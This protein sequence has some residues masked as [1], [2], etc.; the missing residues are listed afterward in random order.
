LL[1]KGTDVSFRPSGRRMDAF[2]FSQRYGTADVTWRRSSENITAWGSARLAELTPRLM[3]FPG[4]VSSLT[5]TGVGT[6]AVFTEIKAGIVIWRT[7]DTSQRIHSW[8][9]EPNIRRELM[10]P[11]HSAWKALAMPNRDRRVS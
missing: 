6:I 5:T 9:T 11:S 8:P 2:L 3:M 1:I 7:E 10:N 4:M